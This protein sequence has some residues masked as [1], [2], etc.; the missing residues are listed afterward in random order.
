MKYTMH[1]TLALLLVSLLIA[2]QPAPPPNYSEIDGKHLKQ[3]VED[4]TAISRQYRDNGHSQFWGRI[5]GT[6]ADRDNAEWLLG[7][8]RKIGLSDVRQ[9]WMDL[10]PQWAPQS[11]SVKAT[12]GGKTLALGTAQPTST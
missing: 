4:L 10:P 9:Q 6:E 12:A 5:A 8:F 3:Y 1:L 11:W 7:K 2:Q